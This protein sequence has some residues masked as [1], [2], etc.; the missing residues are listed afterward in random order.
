M[1]ERRN[2]VRNNMESSN[3]DLQCPGLRNF[4]DVP[5]RA[6]FRRVRKIAESDYEHR[7]VYVS[8]R[9]SEWNHSAPTGRIVMKFDIGTFF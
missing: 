9:P 2:L 8:V 6:I 3:M 1:S 4:Y 7:H 5:K